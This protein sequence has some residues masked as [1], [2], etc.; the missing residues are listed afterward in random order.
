MPSISQDGTSWKD[1]VERLNPDVHMP[2]TDPDTRFWPYSL[3]DSSSQSNHPHHP[4][5]SSSPSSSPPPSSPTS[6]AAK[7]PFSLKD[8]IASTHEQDVVDALS[9]AEGLLHPD[10]VKRLTPVQ[11]LE[12]PFLRDPELVKEGKTESD[13]IPHPFGQG[14]CEELH[15][16]DAQ[17]VGY[18]KVWD[19]RQG[20]SRKRKRV[21]GGGRE[22]SGKRRASEGKWERGARESE[23]VDLDDDGEREECMYVDRPVLAGEGIAIGNNPCEFH[24]PGL[25]Y[26]FSV[27]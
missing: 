17:G 26:R 27:A 9:L 6:P 11:A 24:R 16:T 3:D 20:S 23:L 12:H 1:F 18:V 15:A 5:T 7:P 14:I 10:A 4:P 25:G 22:V 21:G 19:P 13:I 8:H 2:P